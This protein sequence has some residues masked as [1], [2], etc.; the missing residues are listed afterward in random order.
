[1][2]KI[3]VSIIEDIAEIRDGIRFMINQT[4]DFSCLGVYD[5]AKDAYEGLLNNPP[6]LAIMDIS[7]PDGSG[8]DCIRK[9]RASGSTIQFMMF[10]IYEDSD[11]VFDAL[12]AG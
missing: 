6:Q 9:L 8:L 10:T 11:Q 4:S 3:L 5:N 7:L 12:A 1:M 2:E